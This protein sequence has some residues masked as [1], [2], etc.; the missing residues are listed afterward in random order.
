MDVTKEN[1]KGMNL[2]DEDDEEDESQENRFLT[3]GIATEIYGISILSVVEIIRLVKIVNI[4][5]S[6]P[7]IKGIINLRG[8]IIPVMSIRKRFDLTEKEFDDRTC[9]IVVNI[10]GVDIGLIVDKVSEVLEIPSDKVEAMP[11]I[12]N[13]GHQRFVKGIGKIGDEVKILLDLDKLL[14]EEELEKIKTLK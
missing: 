9:I 12:G 8:K 3:F 14:F 6:L 13:S 1:T 4:P 10:K 5:Q 7:F 11:Q 2:D